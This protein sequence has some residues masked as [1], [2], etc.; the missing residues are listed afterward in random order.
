LIVSNPPYVPHG[1]PRVAPEVAQ[2]EPHEAVFSAAGGL[3]VHRELLQQS[4]AH[5]KPTGKLVIEIGAGQR[6]SVCGMAEALGWR[7]SEIHKDLAGLE[8]CLVLTR[9]I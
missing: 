8:R 4:P 7:V 6:P 1:D 3:E 9:E 5:L 2:N